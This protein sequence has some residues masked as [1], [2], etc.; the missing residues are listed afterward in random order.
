[1]TYLID[2]VKLNYSMDSLPNYKT[3]S[4]FS[5]EK[6]QALLIV[7]LGMAVILTLTLSIVSRSVTD[8]A[9]TTQDE[10]SLRAFSAAEAGVERAII[11]GEINED[12]GNDNYDAKVTGIAENK[13]V[14]EIP[15]ELYSGES[16][17]VWFTRI[18]D[19]GQL[20]C[21]GDPDEPPTTTDDNCFRAGNFEDICWGSSTTNPPAIE[22]TVYYDSLK[23][24]KTGVPNYSNIK[25][26]RRVF[27]PNAA[28]HDNNFSVP[29]GG[30]CQINDSYKYHTG[31]LGFVGD[32]GLPGGCVGGGNEGCLLFTRIKLLYNESVPHKVGVRVHSSDTLPAQGQLITSTGKSGD[33]T[34]TIQAFQTYKEAPSIFDNAI[35][36][37]EGGLSK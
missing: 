27:D 12:I 19:Q 36:S 31:V 13:K 15:G 1:M 32:L 7:L 34:R 6:G 14:Y 5:S 16:A 22:I 33:A 28:T 11:V 23:G 3:K 9:I 35:F 29:P 24:A 25:V 4:K 17:T 18:N 21:I 37:F 10:E 8:V 2:I 26:A 30:Q 20:T